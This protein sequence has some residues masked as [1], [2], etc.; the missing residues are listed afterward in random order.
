[1]RTQLQMWGNSLGLRIPK[2][3]AR[4]TGLE[5]GGEVELMVD[6][7]RLIVAPVAPWRA[8]L[9]ELLTQVTDENVHPETETGPDVGEEIVN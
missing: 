9:A 2:A 6:A 8:R 4:E 7:G 1:M 3:F 5:C